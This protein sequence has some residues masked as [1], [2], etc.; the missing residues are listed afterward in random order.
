MDAKLPEEKFVRMFTWRCRGCKFEAKWPLDTLQCG[1]YGV[2]E[3]T[4]C[5]LEYKIKQ[6]GEAVLEFLCH[7]C[8][9]KGAT[10]V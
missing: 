1:G 3:C 2:S 4:R 9:M 10:D 6:G 7:E 8:R 5:G